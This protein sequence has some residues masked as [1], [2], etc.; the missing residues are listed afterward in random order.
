MFNSPFG[1]AILCGEI[2][3]SGGDFEVE[4]LLGGLS[5]SSCAALVIAVV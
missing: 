3:Y 4:A 1:G 2:I 5:R